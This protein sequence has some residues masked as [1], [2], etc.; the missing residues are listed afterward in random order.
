MKKRYHLGCALIAVTAMSL[1]AQKK[2]P[3]LETYEVSR[4]LP[5]VDTIELK[6]KLLLMEQEI[7]RSNTAQKKQPFLYKEVE[8]DSTL[9][10]LNDRKY[11]AKIDRLWM[12][13]LT[14]GTL[15]DSI[16]AIVDDTEYEEV[17]YPEL[18]TEVLKK[19]LAELDARTPFNVE[20]NPSLENVIKGYLKRHK[21]TLERLMGLSQFYF[22]GFEE[23]LDKHNMPL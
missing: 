16:T 10:N 12:E 20:Y 13:E 22:P 8:W 11:A 14:T 3:S 5:V 7:A 19:R 17:D 18:T 21:P 2:S 4:T 15:Y 1:N 23:T 9:Q 6:E